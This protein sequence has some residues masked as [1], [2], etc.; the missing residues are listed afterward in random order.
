MPGAEVRVYAAATRRLISSA[1][2]DTGGG[3]CSQNV[4]PAHLGTGTAAR[5]DVEVTTM[6][7][8]G[9]RV[10]RITGVKP[11]TASRPLTVKIP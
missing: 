3:Y 10:T 9:R 4:M 6:S 8:A 11:A 1:L 2:V 7:R 5:V